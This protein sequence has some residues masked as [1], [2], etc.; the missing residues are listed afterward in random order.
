MQ[1]WKCWIL[2]FLHC[3]AV[4]WLKISVFK[5]ETFH[6]F[7]HLE[8]LSVCVWSVSVLVLFKYERRLWLCFCRELQ[9]ALHGLGRVI[10]GLL[11]ADVIIHFMKHCELAVASKQSSYWNTYHDSLLPLDIFHYMIIFSS[12]WWCVMAKFTSTQNLLFF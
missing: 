5:D 1:R 2:L 4:L 3:A 10:G 12:S 11:I 8:C 6:W 9:L 7:P